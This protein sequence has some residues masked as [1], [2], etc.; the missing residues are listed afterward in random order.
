MYKS[1][2]MTNMYG[3][4]IGDIVGSIYE[5][6]NIK[7]KDFP[8]FQKHNFF[9]DDTTLTVC[10]MGALIAYDDLDTNDTETFKEILIDVIHTLGSKYPR[11]YGQRFFWWL[12]R[13][14]RTPYN[15]YGNGSAMRV[16]PVSWYASSLEEA[17]L[18]GRVSAQITHNHPEGIKGAEAIAG[19]TYLARMKTPMEEMRAYAQQFY[20]LDFTLD[21]IRPVYKHDESCQHSVPQA[22][23]AFFESTDFEDAIRNAISIGGD[24]DTIA[25]ITGS[26]AGAYYEIPNEMIKQAKTYLPNEMLRIIDDFGK[27]ITTKSC[28]KE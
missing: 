21:K 8:L 5:F 9:T 22:I 25:A 12:A 15:S 24:S 6:H 28:E 7:T 10:L 2:R 3:A 18:L 1:E 11:G 27:I 17:G 16:S 19:L 14:S 20:S 23:E 4:I 26:M 13:K